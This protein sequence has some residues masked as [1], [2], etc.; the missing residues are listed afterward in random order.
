MIQIIKSIARFCVITLCAL[1]LAPL[2]YAATRPAGDL[3]PLNAPDGNLNVADVLIL[4][5]IILN[6][7]SPTPEQIMIGDVAPLG[8]PDGHLNV[9]DLVVLMRAITGE[10]S[11]PDVYIGPDAPVLDAVVSPTNS[12]PYLITGTADSDTE[13]RLY[14]DGVLADS[15][16]S[17]NDGSFSFSAVLHDDTNLIHTTAFSGGQESASSNILVLDYH[18][19]VP[20]TYDNDSLV[21]DVVWTPGSTPAPYIIE[22]TLSIASGSSLTILPGTEIRFG[23]GARINVMGDLIVNG[24]AASSVT[25]TSDSPAP[26]RGDWLGVVIDN[27]AGNVVIDHAQI[28]W[29]EN[30]IAV[31]GGTNVLISNSG[32]LDSDADGIYVGPGTTPTITGNLIN[33]SASSGYNTPYGRNGIHV[34]AASPDIKSNTIL[35]HYVG[36]YVH[37]DA[38]PI[39][40]QGN[41]LENNEIGIYLVGDYAYAENNPTP[42][43][44][45]NNIRN[46]RRYGL[47]ADSWATDKSYTDDFYYMLEIELDVSNNWW[48]GSDPSSVSLS[49]P[50]YNWATPVLKVI[51][52]LDAP[53]GNPV[54]GNFLGGLVTTYTQLPAGAAYTVVGDYVIV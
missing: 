12:N 22:G 13:I 44:T 31:F 16:I 48:G 18:N 30:G 36:I 38:S 49:V 33:Q 50:A 7:L 40:H 21:G 8:S 39:I 42:I 9:G 28:Q 20:R 34:D 5:R 24:S 43:I 23:F 27:A 17:A 35:N 11:I 45:G 41:V 2:T 32:I 25:L 37:D 19:T 29:A 3:A 46:N 15:T 53:G 6:D 52:F 10:I 47:A 51:P 4:Q 1:P 14:I 26:A 54:A